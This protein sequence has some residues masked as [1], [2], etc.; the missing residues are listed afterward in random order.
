MNSLPLCLVMA[1]ISFGARDG[2]V[3]PPHLELDEFPLPRLMR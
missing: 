1:A 3:R 2:G